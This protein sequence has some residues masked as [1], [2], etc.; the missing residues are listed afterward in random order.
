MTY[1][2]TLSSPSVAVVRGFSSG[3][4]EVHLRQQLDGR[5]Q[6]FQPHTHQESF[7]AF[8]RIWRGHSQ[9]L[10]RSV[11]LFPT[12]QG[13]K[14]AQGL[15]CQEGRRQAQEGCGEEVTSQEISRQEVATQGKEDYHQA[16]EDDR[17]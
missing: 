10:H 13:R 1:S 12:W 8:G 15:G 7:G 4:R 16:Q 2:S 17:S 11:R 9:V 3:E 14:E 6:R 5:G